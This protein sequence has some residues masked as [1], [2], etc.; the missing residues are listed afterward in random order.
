MRTSLVKLVSHLYNN[1]NIKTT[2]DDNRLPTQ[3]AVKPS[4]HQ[5]NR[6]HTLPTRQQQKPKE[7]QATDQADH[8]G[9]H[10][11]RTTGSDEHKAAPTLPAP[12]PPENGPRQ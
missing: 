7:K 11:P 10:A 4:A 3:G 12:N 1:I 6:N 9:Q 5:S 8:P 2:N